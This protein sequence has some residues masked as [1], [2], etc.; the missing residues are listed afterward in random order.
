[1]KRS[2][3]VIKKIFANFSSRRRGNRDVINQENVSNFDNL[4]KFLP[5]Y[6]EIISLG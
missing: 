2:F 3:L 6:F 4:T 1:M 5:E